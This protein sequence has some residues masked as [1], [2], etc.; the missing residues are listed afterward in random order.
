[1]RVGHA[2]AHLLNL[3][4]A[5]AQLRLDRLQLLTEQVLPLLVG[6]LLFS[7]RLDASLDLEDVDLARERFGH[8]V[9][10]ELERVGFEEALLVL[11]LDVEDAGE[12]VRDPQRI[13]QA[14]DERLDVRRETGRQRQRAID[15]LLQPP[16]SRVDFD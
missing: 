16:D 3:G 1:M 6:H 13:V 7:A 12:Q 4:V 10:L 8:G 9:E 5:F 14:G 2:L 15:Q 11:R